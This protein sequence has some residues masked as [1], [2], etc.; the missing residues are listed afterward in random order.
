VER[1]R[2][3]P[4]VIA[5]DVYGEAPHVGR[6][7]WTWYTGSAGWMLRVGLESILGL[8]VRRGRALEIRPCI[9]ADWPEYRI[10]YRPPGRDTAFQVHVKNPGGRTGLVRAARLDGEPWPTV[11]GAVVVPL[12]DDALEHRLEIEL[13]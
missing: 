8:R 2:V 10:S 4:Y 1:Y 11:E 5:A 3:E 9:P 6:G 13:E 7:G 12:D